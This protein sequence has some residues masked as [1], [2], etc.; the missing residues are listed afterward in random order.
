[1]KRG[2]GLATTSLLCMASLAYAAPVDVNGLDQNADQTIDLTDGLLDAISG[3]DAGFVWSPEFGFSPLPIL[4]GNQ[5]IIGLAGAS[6]PG[7]VLSWDPEKGLVEGL[8]EAGEKPVAWSHEGASV[9]P[10][11]WSADSIAGL[12]DMLADQDGATI[13]S[14]IDI[15]SSGLL[16]GKLQLKDS[17]TERFFVW[18]SDSGLTVMDPDNLP[19]NLSLHALSDTGHVIGQIAQDDGTDIGVIITASGAVIPLP[20]PDGAGAR[21]EGV[22]SQGQVVGQSLTSPAAALIWDETGAPTA[23]QDILS[24]PLPVDFRL[25]NAYDINSKGQVVA[26]AVGPKGSVQ[27]VVL[28]PTEDGS[29]LFTPSLIGEIYAEGSDVPSRVLALAENGSVVGSCGAGS[30]DCPTPSIEFGALDP[31]ITNFTAPFGD[32]GGFLPLISGS[33]FAPAPAPA[34]APGGGT[35]APSGGAGQVSNASAF[36][37]ASFPTLTTGTGEAAD[38][39]AG[40]SAIPLPPTVFMSVLGL[41]GLLGVGRLRSLRR[42]R[43][44]Y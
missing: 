9:S 2:I 31:S 27:A 21:A 17:A 24:S 12:S 13:T 43:R 41:L 6:L 34:P 11:T 37:P 40:S 25:T 39:A 10:V 44:V 33:F 5:K 36:G 22:S 8:G 16:L 7:A 42:H 38:A 3:Q 14:V 4:G 1:M 15:A 20:G 28:T 23:L 19:A 29:G 35:G 18:S 32:A 30:R 26:E